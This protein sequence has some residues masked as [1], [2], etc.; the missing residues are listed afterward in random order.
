[1]KIYQR[2]FEYSQDEYSPCGALRHR[3]STRHRGSTLVEM[4]LIVPMVMGLFI[5][6]ME[7]G[8]MVKTNLQMNNA[9]REGARLLSI[10]KSTQSVRDTV[11][12]FSS[13][14][15]VTVNIDYSLDQGATYTQM[16]INTSSPNQIPTTAL[17]RV[18]VVNS[19]SP[20]TGLIP[21]MKN[22]TVTQRASL[23]RE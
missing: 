7:F 9:V 13:P 1:M 14:I 5:G 12:K 20:L 18:T 22:R 15:K 21:G 2:P 10:G 16:P 17:S 6:I 23:G 11:V 3:V 19:Y 8:W 4:G